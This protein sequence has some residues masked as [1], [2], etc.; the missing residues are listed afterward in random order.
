ME[1]IPSPIPVEMRPT[2]IGEQVIDRIVAWM[3]FGGYGWGIYWPCLGVL[4][5][6]L[7]SV[8][9][10]TLVFGPVLAGFLVGTVLGAHIGLLIG[11]VTSL[12]VGLRRSRLLVLFGIGLLTIFVIFTHVTIVIWLGWDDW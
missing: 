12:D 5:A 7:V 4:D 3:V 6:F 9:S 1:E 8:R 10:G 11:L 2:P